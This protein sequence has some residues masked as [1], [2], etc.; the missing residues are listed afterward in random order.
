VLLALSIAQAFPTPPMVSKSW[1]LTFTHGAPR[2]VAVQDLTGKYEWYWYMPYKVVNN[3]GSERLFVPDIT[4]ATDNGDII[5]ANHNIPSSV[6]EAIKQRTGNPLVETPATV[7]GQILQGDDYAKE[8]F[9]VWPAFGSDVSLV[10]IFVSGL[11]GE[12]TVVKNTDTGKDV[13]LARTLMITYSFPG[14]PA[15]PDA[16]TVSHQGDKWVMR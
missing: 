6:Y 7:I 4:I 8:S 9:A 12:T 5:Q 10:N 11:S 1:E 16:Q 3:S 15:S 2:V 14:R 13:I